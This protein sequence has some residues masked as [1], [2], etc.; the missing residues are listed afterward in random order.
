MHIKQNHI[1]ENKNYLYNK[2][3]VINSKNIILYLGIG[4]V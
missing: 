3:V 2:N 4:G 1:D